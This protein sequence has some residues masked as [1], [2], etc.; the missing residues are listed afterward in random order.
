MAN[1]AVVDNTNI[2][3]NL[4]IAEITD[5]PPLNCRLIKTPDLQGN[6]ANIG[7]TWDG[8][9]FI[10]PNPIDTSDYSYGS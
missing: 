1:L 4:I 6:H 3:I 5:P 10:N 2:V 7:F 8:N 9:I